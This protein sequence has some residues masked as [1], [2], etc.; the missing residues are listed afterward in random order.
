MSAAAVNLL[1][2]VLGSIGTATIKGIVLFVLAVSGGI[3]LLFGDGFRQRVEFGERRRGDNSASGESRTVEFTTGV[4]ARY[5]RD[6]GRPRR[7]AR[8]VRPIGRRWCA[9]CKRR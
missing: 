5:P 7:D 3:R 6:G 2:V 9:S 1:R 4:D 8:L